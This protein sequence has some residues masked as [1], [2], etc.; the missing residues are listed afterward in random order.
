MG[1]INY[2]LASQKVLEETWKDEDDAYWESFLKKS[3][4][5]KK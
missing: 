5:K 1:K 4:S 3:N 2:S